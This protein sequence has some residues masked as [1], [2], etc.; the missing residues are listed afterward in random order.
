MSILKVEDIALRCPVGRII[1][2]SSEAS[3]IILF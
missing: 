1:D 2:P 3:L